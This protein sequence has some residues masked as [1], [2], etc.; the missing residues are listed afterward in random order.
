M[1]GDLE[2]HVSFSDCYLT[3]KQVSDEAARKETVTS[4]L[5]PFILA[6][7]RDEDMAEGT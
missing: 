5:L 6:L 4:H 3:W 1:A 2:R 7:H